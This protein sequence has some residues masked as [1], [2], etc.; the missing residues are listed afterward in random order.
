MQIRIVKLCRPPLY[1][2]ERTLFGS[3]F[4]STTDQKTGKKGEKLKSALS[5]S[6]SLARACFSTWIQKW[7]SFVWAAASQS[8]TFMAAE[9][10]GQKL[11]KTGSDGASKKPFDL[12]AFYSCLPAWRLGYRLLLLL[13]H[14]LFIF[15]LE[16]FAQSGTQIFRA[17]DWQP[18]AGH[19]RKNNYK[20]NFVDLLR[21]HFEVKVKKL[22][23]LEHFSVTNHLL[24]S[25]LGGEREGWAKKEQKVICCA[26]ASLSSYV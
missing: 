16:I 21:F 14:F 3:F 1:K 20:N 24:K 5:L 22:S 7:P 15:V 11:P 6:L 18:N 8:N 17:F 12:T 25:L 13:V 9:K 10:T 26:A 23:L 2:V 4:N 19:S